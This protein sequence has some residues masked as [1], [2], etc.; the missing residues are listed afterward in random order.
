[1][2]KPIPIA[3]SVSPNA[4]LMEDLLGEFLTHSCATFDQMRWMATQFCMQT[5]MRMPD[6]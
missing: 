2:S 4:L 6:A 3:M 5:L 1:M